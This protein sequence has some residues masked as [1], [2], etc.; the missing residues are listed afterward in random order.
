[1]TI[2]WYASGVRV[3]DLSNLAG[4]SVGVGPVTGSVGGGIREVG[5]YRFPSSDTWSA[6]TNRIAADGSFYI[7]GNDTL[8]GFD[9]YRYTPARDDAHLPAPGTWLTPDQVPAAP[10]LDGYRPFCLL[11]R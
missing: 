11:P 5:W 9:V 1:M 10:R 6:K 3:L 7:Y 8:R 2:A 4:A